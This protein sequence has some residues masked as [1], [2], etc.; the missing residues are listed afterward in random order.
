MWVFNINVTPAGWPLL[1]KATS[2]FIERLSMKVERL[3]VICAT[4]KQP[5]GQELRT[6]GKHDHKRIR[7]KCDRCEFE[8][9]VKKYLQVHTKTDHEGQVFQCNQCE[10]SSKGRQILKRHISVVHEGVKIQ[11]W[12]MCLHCDI[13]Q[14]FEEKHE[15]QCTQRPSLQPMQL[16]VWRPWKIGETFVCLFIF[17]IIHSLLYVRHLLK[18]KGKKR[19]LY[20]IEQSSE[21]SEDSKHR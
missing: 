18:H 7:Y 17:F 10:Y 20:N 9:K 5:K 19:L 2:D 4:S 21:T 14:I 11:M 1:T 3:S 13:K 6:Q 8:T 16:D 15:W 12:S